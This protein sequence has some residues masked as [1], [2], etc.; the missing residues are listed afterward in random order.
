[1]GAGIALLIVGLQRN[2]AAR[3]RNVMMLP[4]VGPAYAGFGLTGRF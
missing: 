1:L 3:L 4:E 2:K